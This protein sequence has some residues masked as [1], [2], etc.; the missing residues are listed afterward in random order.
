LYS[1]FCALEDFQNGR[2]FTTFVSKYIVLVVL[3]DELKPQEHDPVLGFGST[4]LGAVQVIQKLK[5]MF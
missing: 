4:N 2:L 3:R 5:I 1:A